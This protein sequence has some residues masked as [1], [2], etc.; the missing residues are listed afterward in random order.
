MK[1]ISIGAKLIASIVTLLA[2]TCLAL[3]ILSFVN[4]S[5]ALQEQVETNLVWK[6][7]DVSHYMEEVFKRLFGEVESIAD[8]AVVQEMDLEQQFIYLNEQLTERTDYLAF[9]IIDENGISITQM[10]R[11]QTYQIVIMSLTHLTVRQRCQIF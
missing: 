3:G 7:E 8:Q 5:S 6:A 2:V 4:S 10:V 11:R 9:G 1:I